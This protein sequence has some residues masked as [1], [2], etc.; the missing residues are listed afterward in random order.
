[1]DNWAEKL[2]NLGS[3][4][5]ASFH[6][7]TQTKDRTKIINDWDENKIDLI[8]ATNAFGV[9]MD[10]QDVRTVIHGMIPDSLDQF[11]QEVGRGGRDGKS[12]VS[13]TVFEKGDIA[14]GQKQSKPTILTTDNSYDRWKS[15]FQK[16]TAV[17]SVSGRNIRCLN[18]KNRQIHLPQD[19]DANETWHLRMIAQM[20]RSG[21]LS[22]NSIRPD[23]PKQNTDETDQVFKVK[24]DKF[25]DE[26]NKNIYFEI[27]DGAHMNRTN[28]EK[29]MDLEKEQGQHARTRSFSDLLKVLRGQTEMGEALSNLYKVSP[30]DFGDNL[31]SVSK[32]CRGC[33][34]KPRHDISVGYQVPAGTGIRETVKI[35][36]AIWDEKFGQLGKNPYIIYPENDANIEEKIK[37]L[38]QLLTQNFNF[39]DLVIP[40]ELTE[41]PW[42]KDLFKGVPGQR[43]VQ[44]II[45]QAPLEHHLPRVTLLWKYDAISV[46]DQQKYGNNYTNVYVIPDNLPGQTPGRTIGDT[47]K[48]SITYDQFIRY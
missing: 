20:A 16:S 13:L 19:S 39:V 31:I 6:G 34:Q 40:P 8:I 24:Y 2:R 11:Y 32:V 41:I 10:K 30:R 43:L 33:P 38:L 3:Q 29:K 44:R 15:L 9:G 45:P 23:P 26:E 25:W 4:R 35:N 17:Q 5:F 47:D 37:K 42:I 12:C 28:F 21:L 7:K 36:T 1:M 27:I 22:L 14:K 18:I 48:N 46:L